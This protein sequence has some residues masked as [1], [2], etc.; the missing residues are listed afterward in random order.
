VKWGKQGSVCSTCY[1]SIYSFLEL[2]VCQSYRNTYQGLCIGS[3]F[4]R[5]FLPAIGITLW[6]ILSVL[7]PHLH[8]ASCA[9]LA[10]RGTGPRCSAPAPPPGP[11]DSKTN[12]MTNLN[13]IR[14]VVLGSTRVGKSGEWLQ[15]TT[16]SNSR[17]GRPAAAVSA[18]VTY[19]CSR[20]VDVLFVPL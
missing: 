13:R 19:T 20:C 10:P 16:L 5:F 8:C 15:H 14:V 9:A 12:K 7:H 4:I 6:N 11:L 1:L 17:G 18:K 2:S 3:V